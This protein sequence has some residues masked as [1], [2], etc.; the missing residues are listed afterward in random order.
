MAKAEIIAAVAII[1][2]SIKLPIMGTKTK[3]GY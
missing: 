3:I 1:T 2:I